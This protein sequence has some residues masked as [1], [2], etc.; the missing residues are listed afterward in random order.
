MML[1]RRHCLPCGRLQALV[2]AIWLAAD[3][4]ARLH[5]AYRRDT[6]RRAAV[7]FETLAL[8]FLHAPDVETEL[9]WL[10]ETAWEMGELNPAL[11]H[12][13]RAA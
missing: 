3:D 4:Y 1:G 9:R 6:W 13:E 10:H 11:L 12:Q 8:L 2:T 7:Q 5:P